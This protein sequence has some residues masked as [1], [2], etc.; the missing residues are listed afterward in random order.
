MP[1]NDR[2][3]EIWGDINLWM[4]ALEDSTYRWGAGEAPG[5]WEDNVE[6]DSEYSATYADWQAEGGER[7]GEAYWDYLVD[8]GVVDADDTEAH[9]RYTKE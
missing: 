6:P 4:E 2:A 3:I 5:Y 8:I 9:D 7:H 1:W